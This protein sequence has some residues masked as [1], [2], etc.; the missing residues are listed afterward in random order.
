[1]TT[2]LR[3][4]DRLLRRQD[5]TITRSQ[6][7]QCGVT[8]AK[9]AAQ[10]DANRWSSLND[11]VVCAHNGPLTPGQARWAAV[12]SAEPPV[13]LCGLTAMQAFGVTGFPSAGVHVLVERGSRVLAVPDVSIVVHESRRFSAADI[14]HTRQ[15]HSTS[16]ERSTTDASVWSPDP[17]TASR[18]MVAPVQQRLTTAAR[19]HEALAYAGHVNHRRVL[20]ALLGDLRGGAEA[21]SEVSFLRWC[22]RHGF[23]RPKL[24]VRLDAAGHRRYIDAV[25]VGSDGRR[26]LVEIDGGIHLSLATRWKDTAKDNDAALSGELAMR[27]PSVAIHSDDPAAIRQL[28]RA[29]E[30]VSATNASGEVWR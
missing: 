13:A 4:L 18:V 28:R 7:R 14:D 11:R 17:W 19:L 1:M 23:P 12:L 25:F 3:T 16:L 30:V 9:L 20:L 8:V 29:L 27:F 15:P 22:R 2:E 21:L 6:L 26:V 5:S 24:Q 10:L